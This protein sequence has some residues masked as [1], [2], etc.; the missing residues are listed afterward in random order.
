M[1][2][3]MNEDQLPTFAAGVASHKVSYER[4]LL[5]QLT[6]KSGERILKIGKHLAKLHTTVCWHLF[7]STWSVVPFL[8]RLYANYINTPYLHGRPCAKR[9]GLCYRI[10]VLSVCLSVCL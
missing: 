8:C 1:L 7:D 5:L 6:C 2:A 3:D 4:S 10:V 9:F